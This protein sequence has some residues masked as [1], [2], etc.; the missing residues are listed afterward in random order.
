MK[1]ASWKTCSLCK[2]LPKYLL[3]LVCRVPMS[4]CIDKLMKL[5]QELPIKTGTYRRPRFFLSWQRWCHR[6]AR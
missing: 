2:Y 1:R 5:A 6:Q 4:I 3:C